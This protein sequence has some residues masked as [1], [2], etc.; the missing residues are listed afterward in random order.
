MKSFYLRYM[1]ME[2]RYESEKEKAAEFKRRFEEIMSA[3]QVKNV[4]HYH[5]ESTFIFR[6]PLN[7]SVI[8]HYNWKYKSKK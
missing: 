5:N 3:L 7:I 8:D 1:A 2:N 6:I 4:Y